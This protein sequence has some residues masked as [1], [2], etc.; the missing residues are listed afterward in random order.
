MLELMVTSPTAFVT[1][2]VARL[3]ICTK[4][5]LMLV[6]L[7]CSLWDRAQFTPTLPGDTGTCCCYGAWGAETWL[8]HIWRELSFARGRLY[9]KLI[10]HSLPEVVTLLGWE[11]PW[12]WYLSILVSPIL[13]IWVLLTSKEKQDKDWITKRA[14]WAVLLRPTDMKLC[15]V[16]YNCT[17]LGSLHISGA[18]TKMGP[19]VLYE[20]CFYL[21]LNVRL[22]F[23]LFH[24]GPTW[25]TFTNTAV[26]RAPKP[27]NLGPVLFQDDSSWSITELPCLICSVLDENMEVMH[28]YT[29]VWIHLLVP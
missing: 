18:S 29:L 17:L 25:C 9:G 21:N 27:Q 16:I 13:L 20:T 19:V 23:I 12:L 4:L 8:G 6:F 10:Y 22:H 2:F 1:Q 3:W 14:S 28:R 11:K 15:L 7:S 5:H 26:F 24:I